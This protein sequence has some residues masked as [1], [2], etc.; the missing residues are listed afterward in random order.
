VPLKK[1]PSRLRTEAHAQ[2]DGDPINDMSMEEFE[3]MLGLSDAQLN[4]FCIPPVIDK[5]A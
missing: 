5:A 3:A 2:A 1:T 4:S